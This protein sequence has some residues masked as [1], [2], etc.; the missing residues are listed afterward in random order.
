MLFRT[1]VPLAIAVVLA[2]CSASGQNYLL[3]SSVVGSG[4]FNGSS[5]N[6]EGRGTVGQPFIGGGTSDNYAGSWGFWYTLSGTVLPSGLFANLTVLLEGPYDGGGLMTADIEPDSIPLMQPFSGSPWNYPGTEEVADGFFT[7]NPAI[8]DWI[9]VEVR[10]TMP[11]PGSPPMSVAA[12]RAGFLKTDGSIVDTSGA[13]PLGFPSL[14]PGTY[15]LVVDHRNHIRVMSASGI[16]DASDTLSYDFTDNL[17][18]AYSEGPDA[19]KSLSGFFGLFSG[20]ASRDHLVTVSDFAQWLT[21]TKAAALG[22]QT[23]DF[24]L[25]NNVLVNDFALWLVNTKA[26][27]AGQVPD[28]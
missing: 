13:D 6:Y 14:S 10:D 9:Y 8:V 19:M 11:Q 21:Q 20:D 23:G 16:S 22:Y 12:R 28:P 15:Y 26:A 7:A 25:D 27:V 3:Q 18:K 24:N 17:A 5:D 2:P 4:A 1:L